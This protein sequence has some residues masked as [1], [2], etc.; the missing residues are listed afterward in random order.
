MRQKKFVV[1]YRNEKQGPDPFAGFGQKR[2]VYHALFACGLKNGHAMYIASGKNGYCGKLRFQNLLQ[3]NGKEFE[4]V[5]GEIEADAIL[6]RSGGMK[7]PTEELDGKV[8]NMRS[9]KQ[10]CADKFATFELIGKWMA[11]SYLIRN[12]KEFDEALNRFRDG[13]MAVLKPIDGMQGKDIFIDTVENLREIVLA[14]GNYVL[15]EFVDT[16]GGIEGIVE[17]RHDLRVV[18]VDGEIVLSHVR[19]P[20][21]GGYLANVALG[22]SIREVDVANLPDYILEAVREIQAIVD[23]KYQNPLYSIDFG[24]CRGKPYVFELNDQI[25]FPR[26]EMEKSKYFAESIIA[27]LEKMSR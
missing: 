20:K 10:L 11:Q 12:Q 15:Q 14:D 25:G 26:K 13:E 19:T 9:F 21:D 2:D 8:L 16:C 5:D 23:V 1:Y 4:A 18:I 22:G 7:F 3:Y 27:S 24:V 6:D 17:G